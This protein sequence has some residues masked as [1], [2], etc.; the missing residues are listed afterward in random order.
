[1]KLP[2]VAFNLP[3]TSWTRQLLSQA[4]E[5]F[6]CTAATQLTEVAAC[7]R[8]DSC[9]LVL[10]A[11]PLT[12][13]ELL[14]LRQ[15]LPQLDTLLVLVLTE[16][17]VPALPPLA[18]AQASKLLVDWAS[19]TWPVE[20][21]VPRLAVYAQ[22]LSPHG[23]LNSLM[24]RQEVGEL[25]NRQYLIRRFHEEMALAARQQVAVT[26]AVLALEGYAFY[27]DS[28]GFEAMHGL[29]RQLVQRV[30]RL[31]RREDGVA[32]LQDNEVVILLPRVGETAM[33]QLL[34]RLQQ[35]L[36][37]DPLR[38][39]NSTLTASPSLPPEQEPLRLVA[40]V[41]DWPD[42]VPDEKPALESLLRYARHALYH[43]QVQLHEWEDA[44]QAD[45]SQPEEASQL[46]SLTAVSFRSIRPKLTSLT[47]PID[48]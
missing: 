38:L 30:A 45:P 3:D 20:G 7:L 19:Q 4:G 17:E 28:Y 18:E 40:G 16:G 21:L 48:E 37:N 26:C 34:G 24:P 31:I 15:T 35:S 23:P 47:Q 6:A 29:F 42:G 5:W 27:L 11:T 32:R 44:M 12:P 33:Q 43:A 22:L 8:N 25:V 39:G 13:Q 14:A 36:T 1:M 9:A 2:L 41:V 10:L 46:A